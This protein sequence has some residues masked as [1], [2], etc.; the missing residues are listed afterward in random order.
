MRYSEQRLKDFLEAL[1][2]AE[3]TP[4][5]GSVAAL[6][7]ALAA[8]LV[9]MVCR[10]TLGKKGY[11]AVQQEISAILERSEA[12]RAELTRLLEADTQAYA[13]VMA[14]YRLPRRTAEEKGAREK[15]LQA[16]LMEATEVPLDIAA[17]CAEVMDLTLPA[18]QKGNRW[19]AGDAGVAVLL[20]EASLHGALLNVRT[21]LTNLADGE[22]A[23]QA[24]ERMAALLEGREDLKERVL[25]AI[26]QSAR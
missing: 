7:G 4:G 14:A 15:A 10:L 1:A 23:Q 6:G 25:G 22:F 12:L 16:A 19:A 26:A 18:A 13:R 3:P 5:G 11:E 20:A 24:R 2:S 21:N 9:S 17:R 8:A